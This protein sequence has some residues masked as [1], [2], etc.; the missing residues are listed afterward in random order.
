MVLIYSVF[1][2]CAKGRKFQKIVF[3]AVY[4]DYFM[5][6][7][8]LRRKF[9]IILCNKTCSIQDLR[10]TPKRKKRYCTKKLV[11]LLTV[12]GNVPDVQRKKRGEVGDLF[13]Q[14]LKI[15][16]EKF[17]VSTLV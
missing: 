2:K 7:N 14:M 8:L 16:K 17:L 5:L 13:V 12:D 4:R 1:L 6:M 9:D 15:K 10:S 11:K 3:K